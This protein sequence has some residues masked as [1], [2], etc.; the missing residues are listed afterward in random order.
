MTAYS[1]QEDKEKFI[2][3]GMD[4][5][6]S[7]PIRPELLMQKL[8]QWISLENTDQNAAVQESQEVNT[9][10]GFALDDYPMVNKEILDSLVQMT[11][12]EMIK[13]IYL[14]F[15]TEAE[16]LINQ[17]KEGI[18]QNNIEQ[19][20]KALHTIKGTA[21]TLGL[22]KISKYAQYIENNIKNNKFDLVYVECNDLIR[23]FNMYFDSYDTLIKA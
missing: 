8:K 22:E 15:N 20:K 11:G 16:D 6:L 19:I 12:P 7:K 1:M 18:T 3:S 9:N 5:Y 10:P 2:N 13:E 14:D 23:I 21:G 17:L 4:D